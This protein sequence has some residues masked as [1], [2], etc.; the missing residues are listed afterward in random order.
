MYLSI[1][2]R[3]VEEEIIKMFIFLYKVGILLYFDEV[4]LKNIIIFDI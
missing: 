4:C 1:E 3:M 2:F